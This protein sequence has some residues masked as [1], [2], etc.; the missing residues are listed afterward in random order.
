[1]AEY[2]VQYVYDRTDFMVLNRVY[3][4]TLKPWFRWLNK[5]LKALLFFCGAAV[6]LGSAMMLAEGFLTGT[7]IVYLLLGILFVLAVAFDGRLQ[8]RRTR[9][10]AAYP[11]E[12]M[13]LRFMDEGLFVRHHDMVSRMPYHNITA[14]YRC[15]ERFLLRT[16]PRHF[17]L[18]PQRAIPGDPEAFAGFLEQKTGLTIQPVK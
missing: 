1:M 2:E 11:D 10:M 18:V 13:I 9:K 17:V 7:A 3:R 16:G 8:A 14:L 6:I 12:E 15:R 5:G 4:R